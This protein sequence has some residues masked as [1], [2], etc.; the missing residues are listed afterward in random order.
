M[1]KNLTKLVRGHFSDFKLK[2]I[3]MTFFSIRKSSSKEIISALLSPATLKPFAI[4]TIYFG[5]YQFSG[6][7]TITFY[8]VE[9]FQDTGTT[10]NKTA[11]TIMLGVV[12]LIFTIIAC[13][14]MRR[15]GRRP[16]TF[17]SG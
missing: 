13:I 9:I 8:A 14:C 1:R 2:F 10:M 16:L 17:V 12:R 6:V 7:N 15:F 3:L 5:M 11:C 4:L